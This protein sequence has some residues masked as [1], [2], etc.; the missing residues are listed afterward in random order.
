ML[1][2]K[3]II[4]GV[5][6]GIAAYKSVYLLRALQKAGAEVRVT[7]TSSATRFVGI[8]TFSAI[9]R[10]E[11]P[12][13]IFPDDS[14]KSTDNWVRHIQW[15]EWA[16]L[17]IIAPCTANTLAKIVHGFS[18]SMLTATALSVR[19]P[20]LI[21]PAMDG[22]MYQAGATRSNLEKA[23]KLGFHLLD[24][25]KGYLASGLV[26][27]GRLPETEKILAKAEEIFNNS[28]PHGKLLS[29][30][31]VL[32][33]AGPTR[34]F[35][36]PVRFL[37]NPSSGKMGFAMAQAAQVMGAE[38]TLLHGPVDPPELPGI[39]TETFVSS[40][41]L[42]RQVKQHKD[43]DVVIMAA[44][45]SDFQPGEKHA[46]KVKKDNAS[47]SLTL[48]PTTDILHWLGERKAKD[49]V[50]IGFAM[51]T[52]NIMDNALKKLKRKNL[53]FII[54]NSISGSDSAF[55]SDEN[56]VL[57]LSRSSESKFSGPKKTIA[58]QVIKAIFANL[59]QKH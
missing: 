53:D 42:F 59:P 1:S 31:K 49:Q 27:I 3:R 15:A 43:A 9:S 6:G 45:V 56:E 4:L 38:V 34:E 22:G 35:I 12:V 10:H 33:T 36:D 2:G 19:C 30:K 44:A 11:V 14:S 26:D 23:V 39:K 52:E 28:T 5:T 32:V 55:M 41:E 50:L 17:F 21:C 51:E 13:D 24:P 46:R 48:K 37:S 57:L 16:D 8:D 40:A 18:D 47:P 20:M 25:E 58:H 7:L 29:G 54:A